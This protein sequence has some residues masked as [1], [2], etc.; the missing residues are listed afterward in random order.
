MSLFSKKNKNLTK[1]EIVKFITQIDELNDSDLKRLLD[2]ATRLNK[3]RAEMSEQKLEN[4]TAGV[5]SFEGADI[6][7][8]QFRKANEQ[9]MTKGPI[10]D[11]TK[12]VNRDLSS[13]QLED[14]DFDYIKPLY[15]TDEEVMTLVNQRMKEQRHEAT[16]NN[17]GPLSENQLEHA[18]GGVP[19][20]VGEEQFKK[21][22]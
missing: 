13:A 12:V 18:V 5:P 17:P 8:A 22:V 16:V 6:S 10:I 15:E 2:A 20:D 7:G 9:D 1:E 14:I 3:K 19:Y 4:V 11:P 21:R